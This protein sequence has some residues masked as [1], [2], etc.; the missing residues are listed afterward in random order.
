MNAGLFTLNKPL[1]VSGKGVFRSLRLCSHSGAMDK[2]VNSTNHWI[3]ITMVIAASNTIIQIAVPDYF[4]GA[5][6]VLYTMT[7]HGLVPL[8]IL[9]VGGI[10]EY[11]GVPLIIA[12][13]AYFRSIY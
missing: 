2:S 8:G 3:F 13:A 12:P 10:A 11:I 1:R 9:R 6:H 4:R 5:C 7:F